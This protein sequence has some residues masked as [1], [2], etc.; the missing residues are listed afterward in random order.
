MI[1]GI[2]FVICVNIFGG[3]DGIGRGIVDIELFIV[4]DM[5]LGWICYVDIIV[6]GFII[7]FVIFV[8]FDLI[9]RIYI[10]GSVNFFVCI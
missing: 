1:I 7:E 8:G 3:M 6:I 10:R 9:G 2:N 5:Y 4:I